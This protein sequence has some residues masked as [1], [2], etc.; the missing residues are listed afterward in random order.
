MQKSG[1]RP[2]RGNS[3]PHT[4]TPNK[5]TRANN[6]HGEKNKRFK[7]SNNT[8]QCALGTLMKAGE[9]GPTGTTCYEPG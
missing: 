4:K 1:I 3:L 6:A 2:K 9:L 8:P 7:F 5:K